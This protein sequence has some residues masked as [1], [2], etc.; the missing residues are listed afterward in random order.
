MIATFVLAVFMMDLFKE[1]NL[2]VLAYFMDG[3]AEYSITQF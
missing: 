3:L 1:R 2:Y